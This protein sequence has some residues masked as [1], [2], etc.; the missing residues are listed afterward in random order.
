MVYHSENTN[1]QDVVH[2]RTTPN[3][4]ND[5]N[6]YFRHP[7]YKCICIFKVHRIYTPIPSTPEKKEKNKTPGPHTSHS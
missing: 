1:N 5:I 6:Y 4:T 3:V 2:R 7:P